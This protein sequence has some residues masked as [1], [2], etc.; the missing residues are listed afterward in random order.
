MFLVAHW[1]I[2]IMV[3]LKDLS[4]YSHISVIS[5]LTYSECILFI[6]FGDLPCSWY[7]EWFLIETC[8]ISLYVLSLWILFK[9]SLFTGFVWYFSGRGKAVSI[10]SSGDRSLDSPLRLRW[11]LTRL[12]EV[13]HRCRAWMFVLPLTPW[14]GWPHYYWEMVKVLTLH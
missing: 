6:P 3:A 8:I 1:S 2:F 12:G 10:L 14:W 13:L 4:A 7:D 9:P 11:H 5:V